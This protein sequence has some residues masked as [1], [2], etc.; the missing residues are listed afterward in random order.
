MVASHQPCHSP[1]LLM[2]LSNCAKHVLGCPPAIVGSRGNKPSY[3]PLVEIIRIFLRI[4]SEQLV[5]YFYFFGGMFYPGSP[6][7]TDALIIYVMLMGAYISMQVLEL[8]SKHGVIP[9][10]ESNIQ[11]T[12]ELRLVHELLTSVWPQLSLKDEDEATV[13]SE[14]VIQTS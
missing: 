4:K 5:T 3:Y 11:T 7:L 10:V 13:M 9:L 8:Y 2:M 12:A 14:A 1:K 6:W